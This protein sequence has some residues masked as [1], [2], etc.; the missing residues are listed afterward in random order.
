MSKGLLNVLRQKGIL[1]QDPCV[2]SVGHR[3]SYLSPPNEP[4]S[5]H[6]YN[7][8]G[9]ERDGDTRTVQRTHGPL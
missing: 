4:P 6:K 1:V 8:E 2:L 3:I 9:N 7:L 5:D